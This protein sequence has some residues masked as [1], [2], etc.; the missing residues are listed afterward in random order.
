MIQFSHVE[1]GNVDGAIQAAREAC[2]VVRQVFGEQHNE[3]IMTEG[4]LA[5]A[6]F[7]KGDY[8]EA[9]PLY[10]KILDV[11]RKRFG[12]RNPEV[13]MLMADLALI[14][15]GK[16]DLQGAETMNRWID[17]SYFWSSE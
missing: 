3:L 5:M 13:A 15:Q 10:H 11:Q 8:Q 9:E 1:L 6:L 16:G 2:H 12:K 14:L 17:S 4:R 7:E